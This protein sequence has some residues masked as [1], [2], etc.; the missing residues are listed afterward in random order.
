MIG[1]AS[2][3]RFALLAVWNRAEFLQ[4][5]KKMQGTLDVTCFGWGMHMKELFGMTTWGGRKLGCQRVLTN[6]AKFS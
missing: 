3:R 1:L 6:C 4:D 5:F 2:R